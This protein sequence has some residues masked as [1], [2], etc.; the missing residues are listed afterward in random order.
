[1]SAASRTGPWLV[2]A[3]LLLASVAAPAAEEPAAP[4][5]PIAAP[6]EG[7]GWLI[8]EA[9]DPQLCQAAGDAA[10]IHFPPQDVM[11]LGPEASLTL[12]F[13]ARAV[14]LRLPLEFTAPGP[15]YGLGCDPGAKLR[16]SV[17]GRVVAEVFPFRMPRE[18]PLAE[19]LAPGR[20]TLR[21]EAVGATCAVD[22][23]RIAQG[24]LA[25]IQGSISADIYS[26]LLVDVRAEVFDGTG[27]VRTEYVRTPHDGGSFQLLGLAPGTYRLL[28]TA[29]GWEPLDVPAV[30][31][32][33]EGAV[34]DLG[35]LVL[36]RSRWARAQSWYGD[37]APRFGRTVNV[38]PGGSFR[39]RVFLSSRT[40]PGARL[41]SRFKKSWSRSFSR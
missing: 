11:V 12:S 33:R 10:L 16:C 28:L 17:D 21:V 26:E 15:G 29:A 34:V 13:D 19:D 3:P 4:S 40:V 39:T 23:F 41:R 22:G 25:R 6:A 24:P 5:L 14:Y 7:T 20:H 27:L 38:A 31:V 32:E 18:F 37:A 8:V 30:T 36:R 2:C 9:E 1:M 35:V